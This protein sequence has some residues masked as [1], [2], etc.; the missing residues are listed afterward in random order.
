VRKPVE[1][2]KY[3]QKPKLSAD[4]QKQFS[5]MLEDL[6]GTRGAYVLDDKLSI[7]GKVP[8][9]ELASTIKS[10]GSGVYAVVFDGVI[11][12]DIVTIA[13][14]TKVKYLVA[15]TSKARASQKV[16][17]ITGDSL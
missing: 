4:E 5:K 6:I 3:S 15:M 1:K 11:E 2:P 10:L 14:R 7:L 13:E 12:N 16:M 9:S 17:V 8:L